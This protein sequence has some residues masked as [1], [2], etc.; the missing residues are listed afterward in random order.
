MGQ[1]VFEAI[2]VSRQ[3]GAATGLNHVTLTLSG[4]SIIGLIGRNGSGKTTLLRHV[5]GLQ[6]PTRGHALTFGVPT[7]VLEHEQLARIGMVPHDPS[8]IAWMTVQ[9][10][11][12]YLAPFYPRWDA[13]RERDLLDT[14]ELDRD[15]TIAGLSAGSLQKLGIIAAVCH[16]PDLILLDE[17][18]SNLDPVVR[19]RFL[20]FLMQV[21]EED[22]ATIVIS[23]HILHDIESIVDWVIC[24]DDG[25]LAADA[26][27]DDLKERFVGW[28]L[29][30]RSRDLPPRFDEPFVR[31]QTRVS[32]RAAR[33]V[34]RAGTEQAA[35]SAAYDVDIVAEPLNLQ[36]MF[37][38]LIGERR[39]A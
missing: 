37:T 25:S 9:E 14:L 38:A 26:A 22:A 24:L 7:H 8:F 36:G 2:D 35:F 15:A 18:V 10:Q 21:L 16:H 1:S 17:P 33:L 39:Q 5:V 4:P 31:H 3:F 32:S 13:Q 11:L 19:D 12:D 20:L 28:R 6:L 29:Q 30:A 27:L 23:S 34:V